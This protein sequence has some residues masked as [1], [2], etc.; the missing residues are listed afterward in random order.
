MTWNSTGIMS[1][2]T[3]LGEVLSVHSVHICGVSEHRLYR[4]DI[5]FLQSLNNNY[6]Y[7]AI[8]DRDL[9]LPSKRKLGKGGVAIFWHRDID[10]S[11]SDD[12]IIGIQ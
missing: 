7:I 5:H 2:S 4:K 10:N 12:R 6:K 11:I 3:Y 8:T 9:D 1:S